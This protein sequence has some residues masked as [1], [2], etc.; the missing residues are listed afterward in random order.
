MD[1]VLQKD[2][3]VLNEQELEYTNGGA[4]T[5]DVCKLVV[6]TVVGIAVDKAAEKIGAKIG[7]T[8][9]AAIGGPLP[10]LALGCVGAVIA[11][12]VADAIID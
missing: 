12:L 8:I 4:E 9:G 3:I 10:A 5:T 2:F 7:G 11:G 6:S 1:M